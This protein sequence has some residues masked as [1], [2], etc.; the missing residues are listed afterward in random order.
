M[1]TTMN[2][3]VHWS[4]RDRAC[5]ICGVESIPRGVDWPF[6]YEGCCVH[7]ACLLPLKRPL[8]STSNPEGSK[9]EGE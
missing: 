8:S 6:W 7:L 3:T 5:G 4:K 1:E 2:E 9:G